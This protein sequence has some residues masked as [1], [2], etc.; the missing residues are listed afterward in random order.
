VLKVQA[1]SVVAKDILFAKRNMG[2]WIETSA[3]LCPVGCV[4]VECTGKVSIAELDRL[5]AHV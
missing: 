4:V 5:F 3:L 2:Q 1:D